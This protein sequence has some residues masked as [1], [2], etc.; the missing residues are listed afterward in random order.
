MFR[1]RIIHERDFIHDVY[2]DKGRVNN[3]NSMFLFT[4]CKFDILIAFAQ[5][6]K[7]PQPLIYHFSNVHY[8][9]DRILLEIEGHV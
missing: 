8:R 1:T 7:L 4:L 9:K 6:E 2:D 5:T 3:K